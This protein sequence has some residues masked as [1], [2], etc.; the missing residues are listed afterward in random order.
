MVPNN[1]VGLNYNTV[2]PTLPIPTVVANSQPVSK[3]FKIK[4]TG[5]RALQV[6]WK[7]FDQKDLACADND[8]FKLEIIKNQSFDRKRNPYKFNF[9]AVEPEESKG[10]AF[11]INPKT[12]AV[13]SRSA[14]E[15]SVT[16]NPTHDVGN[17]RSIVIASPELA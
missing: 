7:V 3:T 11:D 13:P 2:P 8:Q 15:F 12:L 14:T 17:F 6:D 4:N 10:S 1:Q 9:V 16:F 5:I